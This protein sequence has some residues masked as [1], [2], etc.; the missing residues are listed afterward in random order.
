MSDITEINAETNEVT[1]R[2]YTASES[3]ARNRMQ[4]PEEVI[5][6]EEAAAAYLAI[7]QSALQ[8]LTALGLTEAEAGTLIL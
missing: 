2:A 8:K 1:S 4:K 7:R 5:R 6:Q 3:Q